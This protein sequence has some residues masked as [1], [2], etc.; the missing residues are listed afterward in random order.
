[1][2]AIKQ[3]H[4]CKHITNPHSNNEHNYQI[5]NTFPI[6]SVTKISTNKPVYKSSKLS[7]INNY[8][9]P[10]GRIKVVNYV[11]ILTFLSNQTEY[12]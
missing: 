3:K 9:K 5:K 8:I 12:Y 11:S 6:F 10:K 2:L 1:M 7:E 4:Y